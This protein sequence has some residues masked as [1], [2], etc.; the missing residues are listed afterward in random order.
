MTIA[1]HAITSFKDKFM[2]VQAK[3]AA[4]RNTYGKHISSTAC[5]ALTGL[6]SVAGAAIDGY[7]ADPPSNGMIPVAKVGP[8]P[9][10]LTAFLGLAALGYAGD[11]GG[12]SWGPM[13]HATADG[14]LGAWLYPTARNL[15][16]EHKS[17]AASGATASK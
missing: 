15:V 5:T 9:V 11:H 4:L 16:A 17:P 13:A 2:R 10:N 6:G 12:E 1:G 14:F 3:A 7:M 8:A